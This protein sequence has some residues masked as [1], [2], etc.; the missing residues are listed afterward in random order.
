[1][2][3]FRPDSSDRLRD[4]AEK[5]VPA[6]LKPI[7]VSKL[8]EGLCGWVGGGISL[9][10]HRLRYEKCPDCATVNFYESA[11]LTNS[12]LKSRPVGPLGYPAPV[13][14]GQHGPGDHRIYLRRS[15]PRLLPQQGCRNGSWGN[16]PKQS[17]P[18]AASHQPLPAVRLAE[19]EAGRGLSSKLGRGR[20][21]TIL[22]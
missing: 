15:P 13:V 14:S 21:P 17:L 8:T 4:I 19:P 1:M 12:Q 22:R 6:K 9:S 7:V 10:P 3:K 11:S 20:R 16:D 18:P 2:S 5:Q